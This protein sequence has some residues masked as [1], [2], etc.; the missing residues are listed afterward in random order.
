MIRTTNM[1]YNTILSRK[2]L[3]FMKFFVTNM[4]V[5][6][7]IQHIRLLCNEVFVRQLWPNEMP[8]LI[9]NRAQRP[10][11]LLAIDF[12]RALKLVLLLVDEEAVVQNGVNPRWLKTLGLQPFL[13]RV[14]V[15]IRQ[16]FLLKLK[17]N[18]KEKQ[19]NNVLHKSQKNVS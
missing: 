19:D 13:V 16:W 5:W 6:E 4:D 10:L 3:L 9:D 2:D 17:E 14:R 18:C 8:H 7:R 12:E 1:Q 15:E 11:N